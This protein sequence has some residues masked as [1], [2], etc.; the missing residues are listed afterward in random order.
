MN[1]VLFNDPAYIY[2]KLYLT[3]ILIEI[4]RMS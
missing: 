2:G 4:K 3:F 1:M